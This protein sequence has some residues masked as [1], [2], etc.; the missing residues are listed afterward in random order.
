MFEVEVKQVPAQRYSSR[1]A[2]VRVQELP[3]FIGEA[4]GALAAAGMDGPPFA[5]YHG[6]VNE[7][8]DGPVEV[9]VPQ[10][11]GDKELPAGEVA[12]TTVT[13]DDCAFPQI[14]GAYDAIVRWVEANGREFAGSP[15][16]VYLSRP[17]EPLH[18]EVV[19]P[20]R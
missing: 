8:D 17:D 15:R 6:Q 16:E 2:N 18:W 10:A 9:G 19:W 20:L 12:Y 4:I 1:T 7:T 5:I 3:P 11:G 14:L 13:G